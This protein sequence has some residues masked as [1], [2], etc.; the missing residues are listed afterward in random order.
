MTTIRIKTKITTITTITLVKTIT[1]KTII[2]I[3]TTTINTTMEP[4]SKIAKFQN[5]KKWT[6]N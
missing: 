1:G 2:K 5:P 6:V 3:I 4:S